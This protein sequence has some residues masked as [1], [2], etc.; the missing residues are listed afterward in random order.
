MN[1]QSNI[2]AYERSLRAVSE[3]KAREFSPLVLAYI[4]DTVYDLYI[5]SYLVKNK[6][7]KVT[8]LHTLASGVVNARAQAAAAQFLVPHFTDR[9]KEIFRAGK[10][11]KSTPPKNTSYEDYSN[12]TG[13]EAVIGYLFCRGLHERTD[14]LFGMIIQHFFMED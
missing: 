13:L 11:A 7:G 5:R 8:D 9:E 6:M 4:G 12:A 1:K 3:N 14:M 2:D 10:N